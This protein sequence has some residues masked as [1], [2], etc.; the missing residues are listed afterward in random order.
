M[1]IAWFRQTGASYC[2]FLGFLTLATFVVPQFLPTLRQVVRSLADAS[3]TIFAAVN[4]TAFLPTGATA[5][6]ALAGTLR[7]SRVQT[8]VHCRV[9]RLLAE[10]DVSQRLRELGLGEESTVRLVARHASIICQV[11]NA[12]MAFSEKLAELILVEPLEPTTVA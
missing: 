7:L 4:R 5:S 9:K 8:G 3:Q 11:R 1:A 2:G 10:P 12:R 6:P